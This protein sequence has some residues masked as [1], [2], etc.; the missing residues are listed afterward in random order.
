ME[1]GCYCGALRY[2]IDAK[3][4]FKAQCHCRTCQR[5]SG[6]A[7]NLFMA[8]PATALR[9]T[10][11][12]PKHYRSPV[13]TSVATRAFCETCGTQLTS[14]REGL[15]LVMVKV[16]TLD[17]PQAFGSAKAA[18]FVTEKQPFHHIPEDVAQF[19]GLPPLT[20]SNT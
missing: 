5:Y 7:P 17:D 18:V 20:G 1:G 10:K 9:F 6:G 2:E 4:V 19:E 8:F 15:P 14:H 3:P 16:G 11:G 13:E 12:K